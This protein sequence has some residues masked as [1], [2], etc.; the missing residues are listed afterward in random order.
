M[1]H[2]P[3]PLGALSLEEITNGENINKA[4]ILND[5]TNLNTALGE[6]IKLFRLLIKFVFLSNRG[7][8]LTQADT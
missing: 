2:D 3:K 4:K 1:N 8:T 6:N 5:R 7:K